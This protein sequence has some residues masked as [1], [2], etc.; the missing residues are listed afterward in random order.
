MTYSL[1]SSLK[2]DRFSL[3]NKIDFVLQVILSD[4]MV[5]NVPIGV[6]ILI[7]ESTAVRYVTVQRNSVIL[8]MDVKL[9]AKQVNIF[10]FIFLKKKLTAIKLFIHCR[11]VYMHVALKR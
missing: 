8:S 10:I 2:N 11:Q 6:Y 9:P 5:E 3:F 1:D 7:M 4:T